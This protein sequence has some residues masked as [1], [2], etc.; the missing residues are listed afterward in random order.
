MR[1]TVK[2]LLCLTTIIF[3]N[4]LSDYA[5]APPPIGNPFPPIDR[6]TWSYLDV[7]LKDDLYTESTSSEI[8]FDS[9]SVEGA[10]QTSPWVLAD[11]YLWIEFECHRDGYWGLRLVTDNTS[12]IVDE[13]GDIPI[14]Y[15]YEDN[16]TTDT[17]DD[18]EA[19]GGLIRVTVDDSGNIV[20]V[21]DDPFQRVIL[22]WQV[23]YQDWVDVWILNFPRTIN[24]PDVEPFE[25]DDGTIIYTD[26][27]IAA[28]WYQDEDDGGAWAYLG[29]KNDDGYPGDSVY[30]QIYN[31]ETGDSDDVYN[32][33]MIACGMGDGYADIAR[34]PGYTGNLQDYDDEDKDGDGETDDDWDIFVYLAGRFWNTA[35]LDT[36]NDDTYETAVDF[37]LPAG[38]YKTTLYVELFY[39]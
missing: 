2:L 30:W 15:V 25:R 9:D 22:A 35:Y 8:T 33:N 29:D 37:R 36:D 26:S 5:Y 11:Q 38:T 16:D 10:A 7:H 24:P 3:I 20:N 6:T 32:Y 12:D 31:S 23:Y 39:E 34:H 14:G 1:I 18:L 13:D 27:N 21:T 17:S 4:T 28:E 19:Y